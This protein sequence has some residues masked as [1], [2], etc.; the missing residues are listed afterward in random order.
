VTIHKT[1]QTG[2]LINS[3]AVYCCERN[4]HDTNDKPRANMKINN[5]H[6][7]GFA[8][9]SLVEIFRRGGSSVNVCHARWRHSAQT[10]TS[11]HH[12]GKCPSFR[13]LLHVHSVCSASTVTAHFT[14][15]ACTRRDAFQRTAPAPTLSYDPETVLT[16]ETTSHLSTSAP[17]TLVLAVRYRPA[18][19]CTRTL[20]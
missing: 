13:H 15:M 19:N 8:P 3:N 11:S 7:L 18:W 20:A 4:Q 14:R 12:R 1:V 17:Q 9:Y 16:G 6:L 10:A 5:H 2:T